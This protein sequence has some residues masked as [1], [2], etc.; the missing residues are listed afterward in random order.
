M[1]ER[2]K[3]VQN[4]LEDVMRTMKGK[5]PSTVE[6]LVRRTEL[7]FSVQVLKCSLPHKFCAPHMEAF[8]GTKD[9]LDHLETY[10]T[11]MHLQAFLD[12][13]MCRAFPLTLK[14]LTRAWFRRLKPGSV[15]SFLDLSKHFFN[16]FISSQSYRKLVTH[17]LNIRQEQEE[18]LRN[19][20]TRFNREAL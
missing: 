10:K 2:L 18:S 20:I 16:H 13:I 9:P 8:D 11:L 7:P 1:N 17:M 15:D 3:E 4:Q 12:E 14:G 19:Y 6:D 5:E